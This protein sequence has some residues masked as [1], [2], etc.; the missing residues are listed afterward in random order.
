[1]QRK[2]DQGGSADEGSKQELVLIDYLKNTV[3]KTIEKTLFM[4]MQREKKGVMFFRR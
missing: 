2:I 1:M 3:F 4:L